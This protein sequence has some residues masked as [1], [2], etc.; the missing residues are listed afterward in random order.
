MKQVIL[1]F[2]CL[3]LC[4]GICGRTAAQAETDGQEQQNQ[5]DE[6]GLYAQSAVL[7]DAKTGRILY[8]KNEGVARPM[9]STT[10]IMTCIIALEYG[11]LSDTVTASQN[12]AAQPKVHLG[13]Y[14]GQTFRLEDLL[15]SLMLESHNDAAV[16]IAEHVGGSVEGFAALMN[17]K[18]RDLGCSDT[19]FITPNGLDASREENGQMKEHST[20][21]ADLARIMKYCI[22]TS[23]KKEEFLKI[24]GTQSYY[25]TDQEGKRSYNCQN[26]NALLT[27][28]SGAFSGKTGFTGGAGYSYVGALE[29][30]G[31][32]FTIALLGCGWPPHKTY[33]WSDARKL[34]GYGMEHYQY[35]EVYQ[36][37]TFPEI[38][39]ENG[40]PC[41]GNP[42]DPVVVHAGLNLKEEE[43]SLKLLMAE[44]E[45]VTVSEELPDTL[46]AP[47]KKGQTVGTVTYRLQGETVKTFPVYL[48]EDVEK[49]TF[50]WCLDHVIQLFR[51]PFAFV[52]ECL[53]AL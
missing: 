43:K 42:G 36:E 15:Y 33:K 27:M 34:F 25:F 49:I 14:K 50:R 26:H 21:A 51:A 47:L 6:L 38:P 17:Q 32:E 31:R 53:P 23:P 1:F 28:M 22:G 12:A 24:T 46:E 35:R 9:A 45:E 4:T 29:D 40:V 7:M 3:L 52:N 37:K 20:T 18:A 5:K 48:T 11:N 19:Y 13:V 44:D 39:V 41:S 2:L 30:G 8:G 16:M 10:K